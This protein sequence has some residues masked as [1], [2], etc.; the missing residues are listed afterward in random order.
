[1][2]SSAQVQ[3]T[4]GSHLGT[5]RSRESSQVTQAPQDAPAACSQPDFGWLPNPGLDL[6]HSPYPHE[7]Q[8]QS[9]ARDGSAVG[10]ATVAIYFSGELCKLS[11]QPDFGWLPGPGLSLLLM[12]LLPRRVLLYPVIYHLL[13]NPA[14][15]PQWSFFRGPGTRIS[16]FP[17]ALRP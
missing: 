2:Q 8:H 16:K 4:M 6:V 3:P 9:V 5:P 17:Y 1:M 7:I 11:S 15:T 10:H 14:N 12:A 13:C